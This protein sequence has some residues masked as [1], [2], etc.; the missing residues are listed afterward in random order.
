[1][2]SKNKNKKF[3][4]IIKIILICDVFLIIHSV[5]A[6]DRLDNKEIQWE[7]IVKNGNAL[8]TIK[9]LYGDAPL[10]RV[11]EWH[12]MLDKYKYKSDKKKLEVVNKFFNRVLWQEDQQIWGKKDYWTTPVE[13]LIKNSGDCEDYALA[14]YFS[15]LAM[16]VDAKKMKLTYAIMRQTGR[17]HMVLTYFDNSLSGSFVLDNINDRIILTAERKDLLPVYLF[18]PEQLLWRKQSS[19]H[20]FSLDQQSTKLVSKTF[21]AQSTLLASR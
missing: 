12:S 15:L 4:L 11:K 18:S 9:Y 14:K 21:V 16:G 1:M 3:A 6:M 7:Y 10:T 17:A 19:R 20:V 8:T 5:N 13:M 2:T